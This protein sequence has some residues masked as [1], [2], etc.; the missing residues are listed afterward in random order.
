MLLKPQLLPRG[1][2]ALSATAC[3]PL[4]LLIIHPIIPRFEVA[5]CE[6]L[7]HKTTV[8]DSD[9]A[10]RWVE[11]VRSPPERFPFPARVSA[12]VRDPTD[13]PADVSLLCQHSAT[14]STHATLHALSSRQLQGGGGGEGEGVSPPHTHTPPLNHPPQ[15]VCIYIFAC[16][17]VGVSVDQERERERTRE[18]ESERKREI[19]DGKSDRARCFLDEF[20]T[21]KLL[22]CKDSLMKA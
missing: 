22:D 15:F 18:R 6:Q 11:A 4:A 14:G 3:A 16:A 7:L 17:C 19:Y 8:W 12:A 20:W 9:C 10:R 5:H 2:G 1:R 13:R 21:Q